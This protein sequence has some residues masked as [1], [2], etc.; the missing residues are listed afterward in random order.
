[1]PITL[2]TLRSR[3]GR[4]C[5]GNRI[6]QQRVFHCRAVRKPGNKSSIESEN[7]TT[8]QREIVLASEQEYAEIYICLF[9][10]M[11]IPRATFAAISSRVNNTL[12]TN[13]AL[14]P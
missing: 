14:C 11:T 9:G 6:T 5:S 1:M 2:V 7:K 3:S 12:V 10:Q 4:K 8:G 13:L